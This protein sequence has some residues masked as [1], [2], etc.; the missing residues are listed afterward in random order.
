MEVVSVHGIKYHRGDLTKIPLDGKNAIIAHVC[1]N[2]G[3]WG[4][5][6]T[7]ALDKRWPTCGIAFRDWASWGEEEGVAYEL[8]NNQLVNVGPRTYV[9]NMVAQDGVFH[10]KENRHPLNYQY[11]ARC[12]E[13]L[14]TIAFSLEAS[15]YMPMIGIG[16]GRGKWEVVEPIIQE[17][18][19]KR[20]LDV[21][22]V[23]LAN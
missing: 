16:Y 5:G 12:L 18:L 7:A 9:V 20:G 17:T 3:K 11:L 14:V 1:N 4:V 19:A 13:K 23:I 22:V 2:I 6:F 21:N 15:I 10:R 8:G